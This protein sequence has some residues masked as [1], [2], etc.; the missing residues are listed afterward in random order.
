[1]ACV[2]TRGSLTWCGA[3]ASR[4][5][6]V[7]KSRYLTI[8]KFRGASGGTLSASGISSGPRSGEMVVLS[9]APRS[10]ELERERYLRVVTSSL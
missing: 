2:Q 9:K 5:E 3:S 1:M 7:E 10:F 6:Q 8:R 4:R